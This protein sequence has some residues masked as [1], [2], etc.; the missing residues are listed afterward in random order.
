M[1]F[2]RIGLIKKQPPAQKVFAEIMGCSTFVKHTL[3]PHFV[4][5][6]CHCV[7]FLML[8]TSYNPL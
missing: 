2:T 3:M 7:A 4:H 1:Q 5:L 6:L 8:F